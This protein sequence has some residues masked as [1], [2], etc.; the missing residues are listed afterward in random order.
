[1]KKSV[2]AKGIINYIFAMFFAIVFGLF[3]NAD[4]G[5]FIL[6]TLI[7]APFMSIGLA[8]L[9]ARMLKISCEMEDALLSKGDTCCMKVCMENRSIF[10]TPPI[11]V[12]FTKDAGAQSEC[13]QLLVT[14][15]SR[16]QKEFLVV[17]KAKICGKSMVGLDE[18]RVTDYLGLFSFAVQGMEVASLKKTV[19]VIPNVA[20]V[21]AKDDNLIKVMQASHHM[22]ESEDTVEA[23]TYSFGGFP[24]Y[25]NR[26]YVP[27]DPL[28]RINWKQSA[29]R[30]KLLVRLD[31]EMASQS[32]HVVLDSVFDKASVDVKRVALLHQYSGFSAQEIV[33]KVAEDAVENALGIMQ[34]LLRN[35]YTI[36]FYAAFEREFEMFEIADEMDLENVRLQ[37]AQYCFS[38]EEKERIPKKE[39]GLYEKVGI[40][41]TP[42]SYEDACAVLEGAGMS[43]FT[44]VY[45]VIE[46]ARKQNNDDVLL[47]LPDGKKEEKREKNA[48]ERLA[49]LG[50]PLILPFL[51]SMLLS[52]TVF[53]VFGIPFGSKWTAIQILVCLLL[54]GFC[55]FTKRHRFIGGLMISLFLVSDMFFAMRLVFQGGVLNYFYW[56]VSGGSEVESTFGFLMSLVAIFTVFFT[57]VVFYFTRVL[58]RT[59]FLML[60]SLI[61]FVVYVKVMLDINMVHVVFITLLNV[62]A[63]LLNTRTMRDQGKRIE[64]YTTGLF[65]FGLYA[66]MFVLI[67]LSLPEAETKYY[68]MF[69]SAFLGGNVT[70]SLPQEY[71][72]MSEY[73]GNADGFNELNNRKIYVITGVE[74][75]KTLYLKRQTFDLYDFDKDRWYGH[76]YYSQAVY[77]QEDWMKARG[78]KNLAALAQAF[79]LTEEYQPGFLAEYGFPSTLDGYDSTARLMQIETM[80]FP[81]VAY[82]T[83]P[84]TLGIIVR[85]GDD[86]A[87]AGTF[88]SRGEVFQKVDGLLGGNLIYNVQYKDETMDRAKWLQAGMANISMEDT[89]TMLLQMQKILKEHGESESLQVVNAYLDE[90]NEASNYH[91]VCEINTEEIPQRVWELAQK[92]TKDCVYDWQKAAALQGYFRENGFVYD[93][94]YDAPNDSVEYF[95]FEGKTG[96]CSDYASAYV[97]MARSVGLIVRYVE[98]FVPDEEYNGDYVVRTNCGHAYP[99]VYI[100]N[101]GYMVYEATLPAGY[102]TGSGAASGIGAY[103]IRAGFATILIFA[104][105]SVVILILLFLHK[106]AAPYVREAYFNHKY[107][108]ATPKQAVVMCYEQLLRKQAK[109]IIQNAG[110]YTPYEFAQ[111]FEKRFGFDISELIYMVERAVYAEETVTT[112]Q[113][114]QARNLYKNAK[115]T[116]T[117]WRKKQKRRKR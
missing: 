10:P 33:A 91:A 38:Q 78:E 69:E 36:Q 76:D 54:T 82:I 109:G 97:L 45:S 70:E 26:E 95:L 40:F 101:M 73:S 110:T 2:I 8:W 100:P 28:K 5:W 88:L 12:F 25:D 62:I 116:V 79:S 51:L 6:L 117:E 11:E 14:V 66:L 44:S 86:S 19:A 55:E 16:G 61:P 58:Y 89:Q 71:S 72:E 80:N 65:S 9:S 15:N 108:K 75:G 113:K 1:M 114:E 27:G 49:D 90:W 74:A 106:V 13:P 52:V 21:S 102:G 59:S 42:N 115:E 104:A 31:D 92:I 23:G 94:E 43:Q 93:L 4:V 24:G 99:E 60:V 32:I 57:V 103:F 85:N 3:C 17:F 77:S 68:Y 39:A 56:F 96:T 50:K 30:N 112:A 84:Q 107:E 53:S 18:V 67:G 98:G 34:V 35:H 7:L 46:E 48:W 111:E 64:G 83:P 87:Q 81:S 63:F 41:S 22:E 47:S 20:E 37:L 105:I 29:K